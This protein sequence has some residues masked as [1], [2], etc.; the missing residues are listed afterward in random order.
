MS[1]GEI[2]TAKIPVELAYGPRRSDRIITIERSQLPMGID[3]K[4]GQRL[5]L[6]QADNQNFLATVTGSTDTT[7]TLDAN[8]PLAGKALTF[9]IELLRIV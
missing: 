4:I 7:L 2:K 3:P 8:H 9:D 1:I 6:T 5:E